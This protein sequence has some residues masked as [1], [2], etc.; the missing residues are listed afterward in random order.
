MMRKR[1]SKKWE[2]GNMKG[3]QKSPP[4]SVVITLVIAKLGYLAGPDYL[5]FLANV[6]W[7]EALIKRSTHNILNLSVLTFLFLN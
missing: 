3:T 6:I 1:I 2:I 4:F 7:I 5:P